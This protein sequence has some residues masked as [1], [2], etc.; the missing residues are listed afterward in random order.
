MHNFII[1]P[2][3]AF[4]IFPLPWYNNTMPDNILDTQPVKQA[5]QL[6]NAIVNDSFGLAIEQHDTDFFLQ[7]RAAV[8]EKPPGENILKM[9]KSG[10]D[11]KGYI[12]RHQFKNLGRQLQDELKTTFTA[13]HHAPL[14][15]LEYADQLILRDMISILYSDGQL[16]LDAFRESVNKINE[17]ERKLDWTDAQL[18]KAELDMNNLINHGESGTIKLP[19]IIGNALQLLGKR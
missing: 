4:L 5:S 14:S 18:G 8:R 12:K 11:L 1:A 3:P 10:I 15:R 6:E 13:N 17:P 16:D 9:P 19:S 7:Y 2:P